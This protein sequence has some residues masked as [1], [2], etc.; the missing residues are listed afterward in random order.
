[1]GKWLNQ[2]KKSVD[3]SVMLSLFSQVSDELDKIYSPGAFRWLEENRPELDQEITRTG[4]VLNDTW[5][6]ARDG[7]ATLEAF[8][9]ALE[10]YKKAIIDGIK[11][12]KRG[13]GG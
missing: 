13:G 10:G 2:I 11:A 5:I 8:K 6:K 7:K 12:F 4:Q 1:M 9:E 3:D